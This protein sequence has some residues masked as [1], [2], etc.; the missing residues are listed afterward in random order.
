MI[1]GESMSAIM[2]LSEGERQNP[3]LRRPGE[4]LDDYRKSMGW[5]V[6][7]ISCIQVEFEETYNQGDITMMA[8]KQKVNDTGCKYTD[9]QAAFDDIH[10]FFK[11]IP[12]Y[13]SYR[14]HNHVAV[15]MKMPNGLPQPVR[16]FLIIENKGE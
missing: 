5:A 7:V 2:N 12:H 13:F 6:K 3:R 16:Q 11:S 10:A 4:S 15:H 8:V 14:G 9:P 1:K